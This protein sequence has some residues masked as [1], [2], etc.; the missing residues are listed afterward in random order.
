MTNGIGNLI[1]FLG[2][3]LIAIGNTLLGY[4]MV[5][6][7][8]SISEQLNNPVPPCVVVFMIS[9]LMSS[10]FMRVYS[11][12]SLTLLQ[13]LYADVDICNQL[14]INKFENKRRPKEMEN[15]VEMLRK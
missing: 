7:I 1:A 12:T 10:V 3:F 6:G 11:M 5:N 8:P 9:Y 2:K 14:G 15:V 13:C 4:L